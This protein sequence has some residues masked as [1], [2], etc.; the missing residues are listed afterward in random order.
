MA[1]FRTQLRMRQLNCRKQT[2]KWIEQD[3]TPYQE[4]LQS[5]CNTKGDPKF[6]VPPN[7]L[8]PVDSWRRSGIFLWFRTIRSTGIRETLQMSPRKWDVAGFGRSRLAL[9]FAGIDQKI[10][11]QCKQ[12]QDD[13]CHDECYNIQRQEFRDGKYQ[14]NR[15]EH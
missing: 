15:F 1:Y 9:A 6:K 14:D 11:A 7:H 5:N 2:H 12:H 13:R 10:F 4:I 3:V 8:K